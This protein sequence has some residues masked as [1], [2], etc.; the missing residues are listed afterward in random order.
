M[1]WL[2]CDW[3]YVMVLRHVSWD[4][5]CL[6]SS[7][8][9]MKGNIYIGHQLAQVLGPT[10]VQNKSQHEAGN[11]WCKHPSYDLLGAPREQAASAG[12]YTSLWF[13][14]TLTESWLKAF[15]RCKHFYLWDSLNITFFLI[16]QTSLFSYFLF[17]WLLVFF[18]LLIFQPSHFSNFSYFDGDH[19]FRSWD[20]VV[21]GLR[22]SQLRSCISLF[23]IITKYTVC[24]IKL[25]LC[26]SVS[27][28]L[29]V[30]LS[31][32]PFFQHDRLTTTKFGTHVRIDPGII[33]AKTILTHPTPGGL[34]G[35]LGVNKSKVR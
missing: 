3:V 32:P 33:R 5:S 12:Y 1:L 31:V 18:K 27:V 14:V 10:C 28:S 9:L 29:S 24:Y 22:Q 2:W 34:R 8:G 19:I 13:G 30:C 21:C 11:I 6:I 16:F 4:H 20:L 35:F 25:L 15:L 7:A 17:F 23:I 26:V